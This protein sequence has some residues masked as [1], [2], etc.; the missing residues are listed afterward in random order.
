MASINV[1]KGLNCNVQS[2]IELPPAELY[3]P[4]A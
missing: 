2:E 3:S 1:F 4:H